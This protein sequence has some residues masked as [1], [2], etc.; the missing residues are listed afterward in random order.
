MKLLL[1]VLLFFF[2][3]NTQAQEFTLL[4]SKDEYFV[5]TGQL[6]TVPFKIRNDSDDVLQLAVQVIDIMA[7]DEPL[8]NLCYGDNCLNEE[9][10]LE[11]K[12]LKPGEEFDG[13]TLQLSSG[14]FEEKQGHLKYLFFD[15]NN[16]ENSLVR[17]IRY[18]ITNEFPNGIM[19]S[20]PDI[21]V[22]NAYPNPVVD[23]ATLEYSLQDPMLKANIVVH[24]LLGNQVLSMDLPYGESSIK[25]P[26][27]ELTNGIYFYTL[28]INGKK[29]STKKMVVRK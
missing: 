23:Q 12:T 4:N 2:T 15:I 17:D 16:P 25:L 13:L 27:E 9:G 7:E 29:V 24:N 1:P 6:H 5:K 14:F 28:Q 19:F 18:H 26:A 20:R 8:M 22:S 10:I 21:K 11:I 3:L